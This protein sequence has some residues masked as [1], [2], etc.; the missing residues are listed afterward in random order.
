MAGQPVDPKSV[1]QR[2]QALR[3][4]IARLRRRIDRQ[5][6]AVRDEKAQLTSWKT[7]VRRYPAWAAAGAFVVGLALSRGLPIRRFSQVF[8]GGLGTWA[9]KAARKRV[10]EEIVAVWNASQ[11]QK[12]NL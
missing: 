3:A 2:K 7:Y 6:Y 5:I 11:E 12:S 10:I 9:A 1:E 4:E 8:A